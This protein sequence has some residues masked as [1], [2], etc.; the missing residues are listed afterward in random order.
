MRAAATAN[1]KSGGQGYQRCN[2]CTKKCNTSRCIFVGEEA[3]F[4]V[5][6]VMTVAAIS[7]SG[8]IP[9]RVSDDAL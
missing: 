9:Y 4:V 5:Q 3:P 1:S 8:D 2:F 7:A 6:N